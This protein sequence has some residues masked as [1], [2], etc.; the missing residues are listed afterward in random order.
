M[1]VKGSPL[2]S[3]ARRVGAEWLRGEG[4]LPPEDRLG[5][6]READL[7]ALYRTQGSRLARYLGR[8]TGN[9]DDALDLVHE[10]F[11][12]VLRLG[13]AR[14]SAI[15]NPEAYLQ[16][17]ARNLL[18]N[19]TEARARRAAHLHLVAELEGDASVDQQNLLETRDMLRRLEGILLKLKPRTRAI[20]IAHR[21]DGMSYAEIAD[22]TGLSVK[23]VEKQMSKAIAH[24]DRM[25]DRY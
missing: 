21:I 22:R 3:P 10:A 13:R 5:R 24:I 6:E 19:E 20:F 4:P 2:Y 1:P 8:R 16:R 7:D 11:S 25:L 14:T 23:G 17:T 18:H 15:D 9:G 12:R